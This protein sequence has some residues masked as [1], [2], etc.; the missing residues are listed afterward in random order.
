[1]LLEDFEFAYYAFRFKAEELAIHPRIFATPIFQ[2]T[3]V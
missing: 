3:L 2:V 1:M